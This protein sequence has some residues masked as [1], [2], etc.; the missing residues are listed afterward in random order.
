ML[1]KRKRRGRYYL[2]RVRKAGLLSESAFRRALLNPADVMLGDYGWTFTDVVSG[3]LPTGE[4]Y[5]CGNLTRYEPSGVVPI[6]DQTITQRASNRL[7]V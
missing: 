6:V 2:A 1:R 3:K 5:I 7:G 4:E